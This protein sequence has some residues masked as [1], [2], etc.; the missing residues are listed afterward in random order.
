MPV[1]THRMQLLYSFLGASI[2]WQTPLR[3]RMH[4]LTL[5]AQ[6]VASA[7]RDEVQVRTY[8]LERSR[9]VAVNDPERNYH[10]FY[11]LCAGADDADR[12]R[13]HLLPPQEFRCGNFGLFVCLFRAQPL[14]SPDNASICQ[15]VSVIAQR[16]LR[17]ALFAS[18]P[19]M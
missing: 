8:L 17:V 2:A 6:R 15:S 11:Q 16:S 10:V 18:F 5:P 9:V 13:L 1:R 7:T 4:Q 12:Q 14:R 19:P 3:R